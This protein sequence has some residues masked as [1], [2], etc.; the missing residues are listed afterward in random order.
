MSGFGYFDASQYEPKKDETAWIIKNVL[1][2]GLGF[3]A[4]PPKGNASPYGGKSVLQRKM[5]LS[6]IKKE[7]FFSFDTLESGNILFVN[8]DEDPDKQVR[9]YYR[10]TKGKKI[11][12][13]YISKAKSC[14]LPEQFPLLEDDIKTL[15]PVVVFIDPFMRV[16][17]GRDV[18]EQKDVGPI[19]DGL[20][21]LVLEYKITI[22][23]SHHSIKGL[24]KK[25]KENTA[26]WLSGSVDLDSAWDFCL[27]V[28]WDKEHDVMHV[29]NFQKE[30]A[31]TDFYYQAEIINGDE[32]IDL[33]EV[34][35]EFKSSQQARLIWKALN[36]HGPDISSRQL[37]E[38]LKIAESSVRYQLNGPIKEY[39][40]KL[41]RIRTAHMQQAQKINKYLN[42]LD[43]ICVN[44][45]D[46]VDLGL[47]PRSED[48][49]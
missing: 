14:R 9:L 32:I 10:M 22:V 40:V 4:G 44:L 49:N 47:N 24:N 28:E 30:K 41:G 16:L 26:Q 7:P 21:R 11:P 13:Y 39:A 23:V 42:E 6:I 12:G 8:L 31:K 18:K 36:V 17:N 45:E 1:P 33:F 5:G 3:V 27:C 46:V 2:K 20:K 15:K 34:P 29:R 48:L 37:A 43:D 19:I 35:E 25:H 38:M